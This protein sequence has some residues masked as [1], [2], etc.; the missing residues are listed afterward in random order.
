MDM[1]RAILHVDMD[2]FYASVEQRDNPE[3][4]GKPV[5]VGGGSNR[6]VVAAASYEVRKFGVRSA[7]PISEARRR[8]PQ[9][10]RVA[11]RMSHYKAVSR[12][13]FEIFREYTPLVEGLSLDE[14]F[15]DV[16]ASRALHGSAPDIAEAVKRA[17]FERTELTASVGVAENKL[18]AKIAS[19][20]DKPDGLVVVTAANR[21]AILDPL[22]VSVIPGI[23]KQTLAK[24][25]AVDI[26][27]I[28][29]LR[30]APDRS[31][32]P[33]FGRYTQRTRERAAGIDKRPVVSDRAE[34][35]I[36]A[37]E[38][39]DVDLSD[40]QHMDRELL[41]LAET[42]ARRLRKSQLQAGTIQVKI[43]RSDFQTFTRQKSLQPPA[44]ST[45]QIFQVA[46]ELLTTWL[47]SNPDAR[48]RLL[49]VGGSKLSPA[50]QR[51]LFAAPDDPADGGVDRAIDSI[52]DRF[53]TASVGRARTLDKR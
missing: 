41:A 26:R 52:Q 32:E 38:T 46:R 50:E 35:S 28:A 33:I 19:D 2:A 21:R 10:I 8:C 36:S 51:D 18:V 27:T 3:L 31:L 37:E 25:H 53:G 49:G 30:V 45:E 23:G 16:T 5:V 20:L 22:P 47:E 17:I 14:A 43:R 42:T 12:Q 34:K 9:L 11:P 7:M 15:L 29:E 6:G 4:K 44:S 40:R 48:I 39:F 24:L 13:V 1:K